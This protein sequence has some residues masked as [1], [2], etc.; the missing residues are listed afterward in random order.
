MSVLLFL[1]YL[2]QDFLSE[3]HSDADNSETVLTAALFLDCDKV[4]SCCLNL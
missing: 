4:F 2:T 1:S 3:A